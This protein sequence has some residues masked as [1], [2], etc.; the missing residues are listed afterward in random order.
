MQPTHTHTPTHAASA[1]RRPQGASL[2]VAGPVAP[3]PTHPC[4]A[5]GTPSE[6][7]STHAVIQ[8]WERVLD[9]TDDELAI[10]PMPNITPVS[11][12]NIQMYSNQ[13]SV[14]ILP[15]RS[16]FAPQFHNCSNVTINFGK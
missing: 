3:R 15:N 2:A 6:V 1:L 16:F 4:S 7:V 11:T 10:I 13:E 8:S 12:Q 9:V 5:V 14:N